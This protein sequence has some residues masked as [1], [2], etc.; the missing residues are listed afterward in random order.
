MVYIESTYYNTYDS[1]KF[2]PMMFY[3]LQSKNYIYM[4][5]TFHIFETCVY[6]DY[7]TLFTPNGLCGH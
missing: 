5:L 6:Q 4:H 7:I 2:T 1:Q 3:N